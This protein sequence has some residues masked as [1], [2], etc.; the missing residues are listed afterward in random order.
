MTLPGRMISSLT[1][2]TKE[3][4]V[5]SGAHFVQRHR[6]N[7]AAVITVT[8]WRWPWEVAWWLPLPQLVMLGIEDT[9]RVFD[10]RMLVI[11]YIL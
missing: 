1:D 10:F 11:I 9:F 3:I 4:A 6:R 7:S 8:A 5:E 2:E